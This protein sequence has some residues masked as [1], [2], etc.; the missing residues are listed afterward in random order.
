MSL[1]LQDFKKNY[2]SQGGEDGIIEKILE[3]AEIED[4]LF[5]EFGAWDGVFLSN[6]CKLAERGW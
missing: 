5:V 4:G 3:E 2:H 6:T 1:C